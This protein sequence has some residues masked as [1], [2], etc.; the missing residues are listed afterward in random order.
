MTYDTTLSGR[1]GGRRDEILDIAERLAR[2]GGYNGFS[3]RDIA[4]AVGVKSASVHY[5]FPTKMD[6]VTALVERYTQRFVAG[7]GPASEPG[8]L[9]R[10]I[11]AYREAVEGAD[12]MCLCGV[13]GAELTALPEPVRDAVR[14]FFDATVAWT[15]QGLEEESGDRTGGET[16]VSG[17]EGALIAARAMG[18]PALFD[19]V[20]A[21]LLDAAKGQPWRSAS[22]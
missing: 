20:A 14:E 10:L 9:L 8:A 4:S 6:L 7:L 21:R 3:F 13:L 2:R 12:R 11:A 15:S 22:P 1:G 5:H 18:D 19:R 17:L 16:L